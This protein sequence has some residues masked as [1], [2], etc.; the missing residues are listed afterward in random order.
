MRIASERNFVVILGFKPAL[1]WVAAYVAHFSFVTY[2][3]NQCKSA[4][5]RAIPFTSKNSR[6]VRYF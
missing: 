2:C 3:S 6:L 1:K 4:A 5:Q